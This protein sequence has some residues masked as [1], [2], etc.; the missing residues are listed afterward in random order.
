MT[1][2]FISLFYYSHFEKKKIYLREMFS[3]TMFST[4]SLYKMFEN[5]N[6]IEELIDIIARMQE[7]CH[8]NITSTEKTYDTIHMYVDSYI[9]SH[10]LCSLWD[11]SDSI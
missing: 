7:N 8:K 6:G 3:S 1:L 5:L 2:F 4:G 9:D 10:D 11:S